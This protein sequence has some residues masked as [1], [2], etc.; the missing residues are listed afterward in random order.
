MGR[1]PTVAPGPEKAYWGLRQAPL[2]PWPRPEKAGGEVEWGGQGSPGIRCRAMCTPPNRPMKAWLG[3]RCGPPV[4][5]ALARES[6]GW[7]KVSQALISLSPS[8]RPKARESLLGFG[9]GTLPVL[10]ALPQCGVAQ[11]SGGGAKAAASSAGCA[12]WRMPML[13]FVS[14]LPF[15]NHK[16]LDE[17][18]P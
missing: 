18:V 4:A 9:Y 16:P 15:S 3:L 17:P 7:F 1:I 10:A 8:R 6:Q 2:L 14:F 5:A 12:R 13:L 11:R